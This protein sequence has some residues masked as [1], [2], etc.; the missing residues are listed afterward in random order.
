ML[1]KLSFR[2]LLKTWNKV[3]SSCLVHCISSLNPSYDLEKAIHSLIL[4][5]VL[6]L[7]C[8]LAF[9]RSLGSISDMKILLLSSDV[10]FL[11]FHWN[12]RCLQTFCPSVP[13]SCR[14]AQP[15][16]LFNKLMISHLTETLLLAFPDRMST[17]NLCTFFLVTLTYSSAV[18]FFFFKVFAWF[19]NP[20]MVFQVTFKPGGW[21]ESGSKTLKSLVTT[22]RGRLQQMIPEILSSLV[23]CDWKVEEQQAGSYRGGRTPAS[24]WP[25]V[26]GSSYGCSTWQKL[27]SVGHRKQGDVLCQACH[28]CKRITGH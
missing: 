9:C 6:P 4:I 24:C 13:M 19:S 1:C 20:S 12:S 17:V 22:Q 2:S 15:L 14:H 3:Q 7:K 5:S 28:W 16:H 8:S 18:L 27:S 25:E 11:K 10:C 26:P 21:W 23:F